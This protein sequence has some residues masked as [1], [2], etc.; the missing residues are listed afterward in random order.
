MK[1]LATYEDDGRVALRIGRDGANLVAE[2]P[3][4]I[5]LRAKRDG[6]SHTYEPAPG[7]GEREIEKIRRGA[8]R[9]FLRHLVGELSLHGAA[10][11]V[12]QGGIV[13]L[14]RSGH[15]KSTMAAALCARA[16]AQLFSDDIVAVEMVD[17]GY[18]ITPVE[19]DHWLDAA[20]RHAL[21]FGSGPSEKVP[22]PAKSPAHGSVA[23]KLFVTL[24]FG[25][26]VEPALSPVTGVAAIAELV[27]QVA[28]LVL[29]EP[30]QHRRE[31]D[32]L[33]R[34]VEAVPMVRLLRQRD[35]D[36]IGA[37]VDL[38]VTR[39]ARSEE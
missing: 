37:A 7:A 34:L 6:S 14:G 29:D 31:L 10:V 21:G 20:A 38:I 1:W 32:Q 9:A 25:A 3:G 11:A 18:R 36:A 24:E 35:Y 39:A 12:N 5:T 22:T 8:G 2:W 27:P 15:G 28:R 23:L 17:S 13:V 4:L 16:G 33:A 26:A 19:T 30:E